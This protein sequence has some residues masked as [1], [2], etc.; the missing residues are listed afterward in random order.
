MGQDEWKISLSCDKSVSERKRNI[1]R[2]E[3]VADLCFWWTGCCLM[4]MY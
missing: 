4:A 1:T 3:T 2:R